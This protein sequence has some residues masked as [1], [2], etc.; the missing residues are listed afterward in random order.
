MR[1]RPR[2]RSLAVGK[3]TLKHNHILRAD[4]DFVRLACHLHARR[5]ARVQLT[6]SGWTLFPWLGC[7]T[8]G[9]CALEKRQIRSAVSPR[10]LK[11]QCCGGGARCVPRLPRRRRNTPRKGLL[12][13]G[14]GA[15][16]CLISCSQH[17]GIVISRGVYC[18]KSI[19]VLISDGELSGVRGG[20]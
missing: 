17:Q 7:V 14:C 15:V 11:P 16:S 5:A 19:S 3:Y 2:S 8:G 1:G 6:A 20:D 4:P 13:A 18:L 9:V 12:F 10:T